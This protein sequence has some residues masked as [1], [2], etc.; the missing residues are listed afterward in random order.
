M[1]QKEAILA[2]LRKKR[3]ISTSEIAHLF[4]VS[5]QYAHRLLQELRDEGQIILLGRARRSRY[6]L[7]GDEKA[8]HDAKAEIRRMTLKLDNRELDEDRVFTRIEKE[9]GILQDIEDS[10][11]RIVRFAFTEMLN[12]AID[13]SRSERIDVDIRRS[14]TAITFSVRDFGIGI[15]NNVRDTF[16]LPGTMD[17]IGELL[18]GKTT[19]AP[20]EHTGQGVFFT[21]KSADVFIVDSFDKR[22]TINN[23]LPDMFVIDRRELKG[24]RVSFSINLNSSR[25]LD[26]VFAR[27][28]GAGDDDL[29]FDRTKISVK[30]Y[31][32]GQE[33]VSRT[34]A[35]RVTVNLENFR[36]VEMDFSGV[37]TVAH[38]FADEI[39]RVW[40]SRHPDV[41][42]I[43][44]N[45]NEN[46]AFMVKRA[47]GEIARD[48]LD[49]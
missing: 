3:T 26:E 9:T 40:Q 48:R 36:E 41:R 32:Y 11:R 17:A 1:K 25:R 21:S 23:L 35:K 14:D 44:T 37:E 19:T 29:E 18:K 43:A 4:D 34:E 30:L 6:V 7:T 42:L 13:H 22:L 15:F 47:G 16:R 5:T 38:S 12:N 46:V 49:I 8:I 20:A 10:V 33:L 45:T 39:F 31:E 2:L 28:S 24:T 27:F